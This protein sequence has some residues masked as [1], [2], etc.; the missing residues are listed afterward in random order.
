MKHRSQKKQEKREIASEEHS[1]LSV[2][3][4]IPDVKLV[5]TPNKNLIS[6]LFTVTVNQFRNLS[7]FTTDRLGILG[8]QLKIRDQF[9]DLSYADQSVSPTRGSCP[10]AF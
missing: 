10:Q 6:L 9:D 4:K 3:L 7:P 1:Q 5:G 2:T 8:G